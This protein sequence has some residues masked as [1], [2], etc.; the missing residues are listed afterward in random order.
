MFSKDA[1]CSS[2]LIDLAIKQSLI[3]G[4]LHHKGM[5]TTT[6]LIESMNSHLGARVK[7]LKGFES[8]KHAD[9]WLNAYFLRRRTRKGLIVG[10]NLDD[11]TEKRLLKLLKNQGLICQSF[12]NENAPVFERSLS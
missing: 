8:F 6:N 3:K 11:L 12:S 2:I 7:P 10:V 5:P 9:L 1:A 4:Y